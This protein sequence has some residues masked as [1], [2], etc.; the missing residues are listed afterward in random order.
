MPGEKIQYQ[1]DNRRH[2]GDPH[3]RRQP[4]AGGGRLSGGWRYLGCDRLDLSGWG[5]RCGFALHRFRRGRR[6][7]LRR[8][9][10]GEAPEEIARH[11][12]RHPVDQPRA[13]L[14]ELA[15]DLRLHFITQY[16]RPAVLGEVDLGAALGEAGDPA[17][18][19]AADRV[20]LRRVEVRQHHL[21][22]KG[23][24]HRSDRGDDLA[25]ELGVGHLLQ[26]LAARDRLLEDF[27]IVER[28]PDALAWRGDA[29]F[30][31]HLHR[32][33]PFLPGEV[34]SSLKSIA[35]AARGIRWPIL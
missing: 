26:R 14:C 25:V 7:C 10:G 30:A 19:L 31:G 4:P 6:R 12:A 18:A 5:G 11:L 16:R 29:K 23:G 1:Y 13:D 2:A 32:V 20:A 35:T 9:G 17:V 22:A 8:H 34:W 21:A 24:S 33:R 27:R 15:A 3:R 28:L